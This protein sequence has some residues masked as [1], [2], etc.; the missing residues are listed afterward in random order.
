MN[1]ETVVTSQVAF[2]PS[3]EHYEPPVIKEALDVKGQLCSP[4]PGS[5]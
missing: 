4:N 1:S 3:D 5:L 2:H